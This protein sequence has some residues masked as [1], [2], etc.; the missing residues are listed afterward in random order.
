MT[1]YIYINKNM[2]WDV[3]IIIDLCFNDYSYIIIAI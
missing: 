1:S 3:Y 2:I